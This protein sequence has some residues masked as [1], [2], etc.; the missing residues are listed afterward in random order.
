VTFFIFESLS[1]TGAINKERKKS[2]ARLVFCATRATRLPLAG[3][4]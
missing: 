1:V 3:Y 2:V 4:N